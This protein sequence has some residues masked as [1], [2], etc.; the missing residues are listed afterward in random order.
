M[1]GYRGGMRVQSKSQWL[2]VGVLI[3]IAIISAAAAY[4]FNQSQV[5]TDRE[6]L[7][8]VAAF[9]TFSEGAYGGIISYGELMSHGDFGIGTFEGLDGEMVALGGAYYQ[10]PY[11]GTPRLASPATEAPYATVTFFDADQTATL[12]GPMNYSQLRA[13]IDELLPDGDAIYAIKIRGTY[14]Y[15]QTR[16]VAAQAIPYPP[17]SEAIKNQSVFALGNVTGTAVGFWFPGSMDGVDFVGY[18]LHF[19]SDDRTA[20]GHLLDCIARNITIEIDRTDDYHLVLP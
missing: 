6:T 10:V 1:E 14:D 13:Y 9:N 7:F 3:L 16:S 18:H 17:L 15:A 12:A 11:N 2:A 4:A 19:L 5:G 8:Q 20:G